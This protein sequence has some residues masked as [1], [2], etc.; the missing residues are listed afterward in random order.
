MSTTYHI[1]VWCSRGQHRPVIWNKYCQGSFT[2]RSNIETRMKASRVFVTRYQKTGW[3][4]IT[5][6]YC[7]TKWKLEICNQGVSK[8]LRILPYLFYLLKLAGN[9]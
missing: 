8:A 9:P 6:L 1:Q 5:E 4:N 2:R 7:F 3:L